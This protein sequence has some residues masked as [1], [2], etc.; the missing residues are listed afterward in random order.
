MP[1]THQPCSVVDIQADIAFG[2]EGRLARMQA[3]THPHRH[4]FSPGMSGECSLSSYCCR[5]SIACA[6][7]S[8]KKSIPLR[9]DLVTVMPTKSRTQQVAALAQRAS[10]VLAQLLEQVGR[11]LDVS[12]EQREGSRRQV[13]PISSPLPGFVGRREGRG[14]SHRII[15]VSGNARYTRSH[16]PVHSVPWIR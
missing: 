11:P 4:A 9:I 2:D 14:C 16:V 10:V 6:G 1:S 3:H 12:E 8:D 13:T 15:L 7:K 5:E